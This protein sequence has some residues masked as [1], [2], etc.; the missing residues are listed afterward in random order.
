[1]S[2]GLHRQ[3][4]TSATVGA[5]EDNDLPE[6]T[7][8]YQLITGRGRFLK[9]AYHDETKDE[10]FEGITQQ[11]RLSRIRY[12]S[13][14]IMADFVGGSYSSNNQ[15]SKSAG[16][17][18]NTLNSV[19][20]I[21]NDFVEEFKTSSRSNVAFV[22]SIQITLNNNDYRTDWDR[23]R[24]QLISL[25]GARVTIVINSNLQQNSVGAP[26]IPGTRVSGTLAQISYTISGVKDGNTKNASNGNQ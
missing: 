20:A 2:D 14:R 4:A 23:I 3:V 5:E 1:L 7:I 21:V 18:P 16:L 22:E 24:R 13:G 17:S 19:T 11:N 26:P 6:N 12:S 15:Q 9:S 10:F 8:Q 25:Y